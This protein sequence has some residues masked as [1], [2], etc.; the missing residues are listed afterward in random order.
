MRTNIQL[1][2]TAILVH[3]QLEVHCFK[4]CSWNGTTQCT[5]SLHW[6]KQLFITSEHEPVVT[7]GNT[8]WRNKLSDLLYMK[9]SYENSETRGHLPINCCL[10]YSGW[11]IHY[12]NCILPNSSVTCKFIF[13]NSVNAIPSSTTSP[14]KTLAMPDIAITTFCDT[15]QP[16][17]VC[18]N[19]K[20]RKYYRNKLDFVIFTTRTSPQRF[21]TNWMTY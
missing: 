18:I 19:W 10:G 11:I 5:K 4:L 14:T 2:G 16:V 7:C 12:V 21:T 1:Q 15:E 3:E 8:V 13:C 9:S 20:N 17:I 6:D